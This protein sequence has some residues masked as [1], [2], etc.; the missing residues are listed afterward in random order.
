MSKEFKIVSIGAGNIASHLV[1]AMSEVGCQITQVFSRDIAHA[2][3][4]ARKVKAKAINDLSKIETDADLYLIMVHDDA[5]R[6]VTKQL[7]KL[8]PKQFLA[9]T[10]GATPTN[11]LQK[12][13]INYGSFYPLQSFKKKKK[14]TLNEVPFLIYGSN[15][16]TTRKY[17]MLARQLSPKVKETNDSERKKYHLSA[18]I[19]NNFSNHLACLT[20]KF[21]DDNKLDPKVLRAI[22]ETTYDRILNQKPCE[23]QTGPAIREDDKIMKDHLKLLKEDKHLSAVYKAMSK[24]IAASIDKEKDEQ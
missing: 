18:V 11:F 6:E 3:S 2:R 7:P 15:P 19:L 4:L 12:T 14:V 8:G 21:L 16:K 23:I 13:A 22:A 5:I 17:R 24:S 10:S 20:D 9:H 1:P